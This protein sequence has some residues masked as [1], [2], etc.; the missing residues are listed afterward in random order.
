MRIALTDFGIASVAEAT[1]H[2]TTAARTLRYAAPEAATGVIGTAADYWSL[3]MVVLEAAS[4]RHPYAGLSDAVLSYQLVTQ[5]VDCGGAA[6]PWRTLCRGLLRRDP[7]QRWGRAEI[8]RWLAGDATLQVA[9]EATPT[10][11]AARNYRPYKFQ[12]VECWTARE[13]AV[14]LAQHWDEGVKDL[15]QGFILPWLRDELRDQ[16][17]ARVVLDL[18][19]SKKKLNDDERLLRLLVK[20]A[21]DLPPVWKQ[22]SLAFDDLMAAANSAIKG[23]NKTQ[24]ELAEIFQRDVLEMYGDSG[25]KECRQV[26]EKWQQAVKEH[27][28]AWSEMVKNGISNRL[29]PDQ[30]TVLPAL[31]LVTSSPSFCKQLKSKIDKTAKKLNTLPACLNKWLNKPMNGASL[32]LCTVVEA[33]LRLEPMVSKLAAFRKEFS[34]LS[35]SRE[36]NADLNQME[37]DIYAGVYS[38]SAELQNALDSLKIK[39]EPLDKA[40]RQYHELLSSFKDELFIIIRR[41]NC[42]D[43][44]KDLNKIIEYLGDAPLRPRL[45]SSLMGLQLI[46][47]IKLI[48]PKSLNRRR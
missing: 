27:D 43:A 35:E 25:N 41:D 15:R 21:P 28:Q 47:P 45:R 14:Q 40:V 39:I 5:P 38:N 29:R 4:G 42:L 3:G 12:G 46:A 11:A 17:L 48:A 19:S 31:L 33:Q 13:L 7:K 30:A 8:E 22:Q 26:R 6:E 36:F 23:N 34:M 37:N 44:T 9:I 2:F 16:D 32:A 18:N 20:M 1:Q 24:K 10:G